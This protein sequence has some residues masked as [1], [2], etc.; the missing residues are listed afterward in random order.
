M[1]LKDAIRTIPD[2]PRK[3]IMFRDVTTLMGDPRAFRQ[4]VDELVQPW[5]GAKIDKVAGSRRAGSFLAGR[6]RTS[7]RRGSCRYARRASCL[8][9]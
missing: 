3:G 8:T 5:A 1:E 4:A 6:W 9:T 7:C 2:F